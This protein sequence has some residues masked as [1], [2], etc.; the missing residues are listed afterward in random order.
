[1]M[2]ADYLMSLGYRF[3][4]QI[5]QCIFRFTKVDCDACSRHAEQFS[6]VDE[7]RQEAT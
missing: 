1:M 2:M 6:I 3:Q 4:L 5:L 7:T